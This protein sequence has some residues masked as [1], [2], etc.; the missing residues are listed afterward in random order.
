MREDTKTSRIAVVTAP[1]GGL[2]TYQDPVTTC[3]TSRDTWNVADL[4]S[5]RKGIP[6]RQKIILLA[7]L[8]I[9]LLVLGAVLS[10]GAWAAQLPELLGQEI[11]ASF[12]GKSIVTTTKLQLELHSGTVIECKEATF[13]GIQESDTLGAVHISFTGCSDGVFTCKTKSDT[14]GEILSLGKMHYVDDF[15]SA[16]ISQLGVAVLLLMNPATEIECGAGLVK[17]Q[18]SG[19]LLCLVLEPLASKESHIFHCIHRLNGKSENEGKGEQAETV[20]WGDGAGEELKAVLL[21]SINGSAAEEASVLA[22]A[23]F[24]FS[25]AVAFMDE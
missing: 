10:T 12:S 2:L 13:T 17:I 14:A 4:A 19:K 20:Y 18:V 7:K 1:L 16:E 24:T 8:L 11:G 23:E 6:M 5:E 3:V 25:I 15:L 22:L 9:S 21:A